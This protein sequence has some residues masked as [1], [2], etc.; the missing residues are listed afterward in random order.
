MKKTFYII[1]GMTVLLSSCREDVAEP[2]PDP[3]QQIWLRARVENVITMSRAPFDP[4]APDKQNPLKV[5][6]W[7]S[8]T[9]YDF[10]HE[11]GKNG[12]DGTVALHTTANFTAGSEQL[13]NDAVYPKSESDGSSPKP[14]YFVGLHPQGV[15][16]NPIDDSNPTGDS[17]KAVMTFNGSQDVMFAP[18]K[19]GEYGQNKTEG[20]WPTFKFK[21]L[22][23][24]LTV[25]VIADGEAVSEAWGKLKSL[26]VRCD[27][28]NTVTID[29]NKNKEDPDDN[30][31]YDDI[32]NPEA[33][34]SFPKTEATL[35]FYK[36]GT[37]G[38][39]V[40]E[41]DESTWI[42]IPYEN[43]KKK[44]AYVLC[45]PVIAS[46]KDGDYKTYEYTLI[47]ETE[48][49]TVEV[50]VDLMKGVPGDSENKEPP[51]CFEG[52]TM[53]CHFTLNLTFK[54]GN[55]IMLTSAADD[56]NLGGISSGS[57]SPD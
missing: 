16:S 45:P 42:E 47:V 23:T 46:E 51:V 8:T 54:M 49:R 24:W 44:V 2:C 40:S 4:Q 27:V 21:H 15:W 6:V 50:P 30:S 37:D 32:N 38:L 41:T 14:V 11:D 20:S 18:Q 5:D 48:Q 33:R 55:N 25:T 53:N 28:G 10:K 34:A 26:K 57:V 13:L 39:F 17:Q 56:W 36:T 31:D 19:K 22:L 29:L 9:P 1:C 7:A 43:N 52:S 12:S 35:D 3:A